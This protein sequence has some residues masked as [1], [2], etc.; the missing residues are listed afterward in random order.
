MSSTGQK[1]KVAKKSSDE[2]V[3]NNKRKESPTINTAVQYFKPT[4]MINQEPSLL[5]C[6]V[7]W[8]LASDVTHYGIT[9]EI[10]KQ[11]SFIELKDRMKQLPV[12]DVM[13]RFFENI[14][15]MAS[16]VPDAHRTR[17]V[18]F[19]ISTGIIPSVFLLAYH[20]ISY[21]KKI[22]DEEKELIKMTVE[23]L[24]LLEDVSQVIRTGPAGF[25]IKVAFNEMSKKAGVFVRFFQ[26]FMDLFSKM[27]ECK[28]ERYITTYKRTIN[29]IY[30]FRLEL[31]QGNIDSCKHRCDKKQVD[32]DGIFKASMGVEAINIIEEHRVEFFKTHH[33]AKLLNAPSRCAS[34]FDGEASRRL[35]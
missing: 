6:L 16:D 21:F 11:L 2:D 12:Q 17:T 26:G 32:I 27:G 33:A 35:H 1:V 18:T 4:R 34:G 13:K 9:T 14:T 31:E 7:S 22:G 20:P 15:M 19:A 23:M 10:A 30:R 3:N 24:R 25:D 29:T 8:K 28:K 5:T